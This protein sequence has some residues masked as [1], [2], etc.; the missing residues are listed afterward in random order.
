MWAEDDNR[1]DNA[2]FLFY[3]TGFAMKCTE[4]FIKQIFPVLN[5]NRNPKTIFFI[6]V[7]PLLYHGLCL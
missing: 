4:M 1:K 3:V 6:I 2:Q 5:F 7:A